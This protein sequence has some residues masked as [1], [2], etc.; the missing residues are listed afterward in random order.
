MRRSYCG[1]IEA[2]A[3]PPLGW[4]RPC[5]ASCPALH[6]V[7]FLVFYLMFFLRPVFPFALTPSTFGAIMAE[8]PR[9]SRHSL[10]S[11]L[12]NA[13]IPPVSL[14]ALSSAEGRKAPQAPVSPVL[15][16]AEGKGTEEFDAAL[17]K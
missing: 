15:S 11:F 2:A 1:G 7:C 12:R 17:L 3:G 13:A 10:C 16:E 5:V 14:P 8:M 9:P 6:Y 4:G